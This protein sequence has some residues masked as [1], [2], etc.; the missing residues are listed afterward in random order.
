MRSCTGEYI[1]VHACG[2]A[3]HVCGGGEGEGKGE[4]AGW[5]KFLAD[6]ELS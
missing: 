2:G 4:G 3:A 6:L 1:C 5:G